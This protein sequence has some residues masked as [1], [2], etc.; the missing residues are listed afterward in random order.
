[1]ARRIEVGLSGFLFKLTEK[2]ILSKRV[3]KYPD[4]YLIKREHAPSA[5]LYSVPGGRIEF[6]ETCDAGL[7]R[8]LKEETGYTVGYL[9]D[10]VPKLTDGKH[11]APKFN[12]LITDQI[13]SLSQTSKQ[14]GSE[15]DCGK[16]GVSQPREEQKFVHYVIASKL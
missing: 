6:D 7:K 1:M 9:H 10:L 2:A 14:G 4:I 8:E 11:T 12:F 15:S 3:P 13:Y 16:S 5:G